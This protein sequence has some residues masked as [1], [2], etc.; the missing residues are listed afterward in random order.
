MGRSV[1]S[2]ETSRRDSGEATPPT[3]LLE[4]PPEPTDGARVLLIDGPV[5][6][7]RARLTPTVRRYVVDA[8]D[9]GPVLEGLAPSVLPPGPRSA[10]GATGPLVPEEIL[11]ASGRPGE[12]RPTPRMSALD[13]IRVFG[14]LG[15]EDRTEGEPDAPAWAQPR[16]IPATP[17]PRPPGETAGVAELSLLELLDELVPVTA[18]RPSSQV[19]TSRRRGSRGRRR[20]L[21]VLTAAAVVA[22][23]TALVVGGRLLDESKPDQGTT[24]V[25]PGTPTGTTAPAPGG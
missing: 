25:V 18:P 16:A 1:A 11:A 13:W 2:P 19:R 5:E 12:P 3:I 7:Y 20:W 6:A 15:S 4:L 23:P 8:S 17:A 14:P 10:P 9:F 21:P 22:V 24:D